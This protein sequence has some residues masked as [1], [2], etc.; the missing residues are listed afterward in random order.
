MD[1]GSKHLS[2]EREKICLVAKEL[3]RRGSFRT[4]VRSRLL[5]GGGQIGDGV[6]T[7]VYGGVVMAHRWQLGPSVEARLWQGRHL[8]L[9]SSIVALDLD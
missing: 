2:F 3:P 8:L 6:A 4:G 5:V 7:C 9:R 1:G